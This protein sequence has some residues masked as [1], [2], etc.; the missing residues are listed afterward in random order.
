MR[1]II[2]KLMAFLEP[3]EL[4]EVP[5][6]AVRIAAAVR[7]KV[8]SWWSSQVVYS[9][10]WVLIQEE[11]DIKSALSRRGSRGG[12]GGGIFDTVAILCYS[13]IYYTK[14]KRQLPLIRLFKLKK[15][16]NFRDRRSTVCRESHYDWRAI[17]IAQPT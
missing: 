9:Q 7:R 11:I 5:K 4:H 8:G 17:V 16:S 13:N 15:W 6:S 3:R 2:L 14:L 10:L 1:F 12:L